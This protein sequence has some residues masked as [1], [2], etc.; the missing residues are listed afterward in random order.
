MLYIL[1][2]E[3][4]DTFEDCDDETIKKMLDSTEDPSPKFIAYRIR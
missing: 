2:N 4:I 3:K 1:K